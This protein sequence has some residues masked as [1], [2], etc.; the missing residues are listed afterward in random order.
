MTRILN[1]IIG[2]VFGI[3][4][5]SSDFSGVIHSDATIPVP[6]IHPQELDC[7]AKTIYFEAR[8]EPLA[9][10]LAVGLVV[11]NRTTSQK[12]PTTVCG[13]TQQGRYT[14]STTAKQATSTMKACQFSWY[15]DGHSD[16][17]KEHLAWIQSQDIA[18]ILLEQKI[19]DFTDHATH[20][21]AQSIHPQW[22]QSLNRVGSI[23]SHTFYR[24]PRS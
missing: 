10:K 4:L 9:G 11:L 20:Y 2:A 22:A 3:I 21:H 16:E 13:V 24:E 5:V 19:Y 23:G 7:L 15:C 1:F 14:N 12:F 8:Q 18:K 6:Q 17:P